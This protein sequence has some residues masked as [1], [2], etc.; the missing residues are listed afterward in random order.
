[1]G[2]VVQIPLATIIV[3][4]DDQG[5][6]ET[7]AEFFTMSGYRVYEAPNARDA[8]EILDKHKVD[9]LTTDISKPV[10]DGF[11]LT[12]IVK[13]EYGIP[14]IIATGYKG[15]TIEEAMKA[16]ADILVYKPVKFAE[17]LSH[18]RSLLGKR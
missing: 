3:A 11:E 16:G 6:R 5:I 7:L 10:M 4:D 1:M 12:R 17:L 2:N 18:V 8:L 15:H 14:V 9:L 13:A